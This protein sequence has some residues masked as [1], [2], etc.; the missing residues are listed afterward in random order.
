[1]SRRLPDPS[2]SLCL[3]P[4]AHWIGELAA[5]FWQYPSQRMTLVGVTGTNGKT[6]ITHLIEHLC[7]EVGRP[8]ALLGTLVNRWSGHSVTSTHT[9]A[10]ADL[11]QAQ[12]AKAVAGGTQV[13]AMEVSSHALDQGRV[14]G[15]QFSA[16]VF[17]NL[18]QDHL[19]YHPSMQAY[20]CLLYTS[21]S[22][23]DR[24]KS[25]MPSSA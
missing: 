1:M 6:T 18:T 24:Q 11:L 21:P 23:R 14:A 9:T 15:C 12:L 10:I 5:A 25:R 8:A 13:A 4:V 22:P 3:L 20:F 16:A 7:E 17:T 2:V 19:D